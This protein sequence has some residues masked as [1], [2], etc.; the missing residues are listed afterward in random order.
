MSRNPSVAVGDRFARTGQPDKV[1][2]VTGLRIRPGEPPHANLTLEGG[3][4][5][6]L[7]GVSVLSDRTLYQ[8]VQP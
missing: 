4:G 1:Y 3:G 2:V 8:R 5:P 6:I 7:I